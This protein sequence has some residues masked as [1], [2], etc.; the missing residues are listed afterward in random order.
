MGPRRPNKEKRYGVQYNSK[1]I[2]D[3]IVEDT[4]KKGPKVKTVAY[5]NIIQ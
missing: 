2:I 3:N 1:K 5:D 4:G